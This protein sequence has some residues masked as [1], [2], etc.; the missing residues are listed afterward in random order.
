MHR[1]HTCRQCK[2]VLSRAEAIIIRS[3]ER[4]HSGESTAII[5]I[6]CSSMAALIDAG[7]HVAYLV[8]M[9]RQYMPALSMYSCAATPCTRAGLPRSAFR[10]SI[11]L[12][13][14]ATASGVSYGNVFK[15]QALSEVPLLVRTSPLH[16]QCARSALLMAQECM[17]QST[18]AS[19]SNS[20]EVDTCETCC[21][22]QIDHTSQGD[23]KYAGKGRH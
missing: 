8:I 18:S 13:A 3:C 12:L 7:L 21:A 20:L 19:C 6:C 5:S 16:D 11:S 9:H 17:R 15:A 2:C 23:R 14:S 4:S 1:L 22:L 10:L